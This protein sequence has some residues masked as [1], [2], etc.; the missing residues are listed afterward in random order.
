MDHCN[1]I[2]KE[3]GALLGTKQPLTFVDDCC[4]LQLSGIVI[5]MQRDAVNERIVISGFVA[6]LPRVADGQ[7]LEQLL[8]GNLYW[9]VGATI[10]LE[11]ASRSVLLLHAEPM[12]GLN[13]QQLL[14]RLEY[15]VQVVSECRQRM[16]TYLQR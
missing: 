1:I 2:V 8:A 15:F 6:D 9:R 13:A 14:A 3:L 16:A 10:C 5:N 4:P 12:L 11:P 7:L